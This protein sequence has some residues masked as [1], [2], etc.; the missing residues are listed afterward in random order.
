[1][2]DL[3][4]DEEVGFATIVSNM[5]MSFRK[6]SVPLWES[7]GLSSGQPKVLRY[8]LEHDG[9]NQKELSECCKV[10]GATITSLLSGLEK[11]GLVERKIPENNRR[12]KRVYLTESGR[13][14]IEA[15]PG[16]FRKLHDMCSADLTEEEISTFLIL[17][18]KVEASLN[19]Q[20]D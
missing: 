2:N 11:K 4:K 7:I 3:F 1:M 18:Q 8:L 20:S 12:E 10:E 15:L 19:R 9:C 13:E 5:I 16:A 17:C 6:V 14:K